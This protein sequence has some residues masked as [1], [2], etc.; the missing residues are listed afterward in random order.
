MKEK[1]RFRKRPRMEKKEWVKL[2]NRNSEHVH[3]ANNHDDQ[4]LCPAEKT[5]LESLTKK[6]K[7]LHCRR[8]L[9]ESM[10]RGVTWG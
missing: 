5:K 9:P 8:A 7:L 10:G 3:P 4:D 1:K 2:L 6:P